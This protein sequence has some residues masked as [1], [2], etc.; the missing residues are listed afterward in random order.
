MRTRACE[1]ECVS[2]FVCAVCSGAN[3]MFR[4]FLFGLFFFAFFSF[5]AFARCV[6]CELNKTAH[7]PLLLLLNINLN[8]KY[9]S[10]FFVCSFVVLQYIQRV[11]FMFIYNFTF[12]TLTLSR[13]TSIYY[14]HFTDICS[15]AYQWNKVLPFT[16]TPDSGVNDPVMHG[17]FLGTLH[18]FKRTRVHRSIR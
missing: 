11:F 7:V 18:N 8:F 17:V 15:Y 5:R 2:V 9:C 13:A 6:I 1:Y 3:L 12:I 16:R 14:V 4:F 10:K